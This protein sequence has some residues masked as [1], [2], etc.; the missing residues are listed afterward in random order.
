MLTHIGTQQ[1]DT[2]RL[3][4]RRFILDDDEAMLKY[5]IA[6]EE[7]QALYVVPAYKTKDSVRE[8]LN[9]YQDSYENSSYYRWAIILKESNE[10]IGEVAYWTIDDANHFGEIGYCIG[11][12]FQCR[13]FATEATK[14]VIKYG[15]TKIN[16]HKIQ[17]CH[18]SINTPSNRVIEKVGCK[19]DGTLRDSFFMNG[20][21][22]DRVVHSILKSE[23]EQL[24]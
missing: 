7:M 2:E 11:V 14:A 16:L 6:N 17:I 24:K 5:W 10:C 20:Q 22:I 23:Y 21:Y 13:G 9:T 18:M 15:F 4:L 8:L 12:E 1:I 19:Y 3:I